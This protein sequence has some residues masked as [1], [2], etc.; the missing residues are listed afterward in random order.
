VHRAATLVPKDAVLFDPGTRKARVFVAKSG[1]A[2]QREVRVGF[3]N[4]RYVEIIGDSVTTSDKVIVAG[5]TSLQDGDTIR[6]Q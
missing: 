4:P 2:D 5:Q 1:K 6:V 3:S